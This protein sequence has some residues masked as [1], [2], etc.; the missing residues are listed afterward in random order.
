MHNCFLLKKCLFFSC[1][2]VIKV[3]DIINFC[4]VFRKV[5][6][7]LIQNDVQNIKLT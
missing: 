1:T 7:D 4:T 2:T 5:S 6:D 3:S